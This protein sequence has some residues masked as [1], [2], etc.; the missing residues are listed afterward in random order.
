MYTSVILST[1]LL[2]CKHHHHL[3]PQLLILQKWSKILPILLPPVPHPSALETLILLPMS[4]LL[5]TL[6]T[7]YKWNHVVF[8]FSW[9]GYFTWCK[10]SQGPSMLMQMAG[11][12][13][14]FTAEFWSVVYMPHFPYPFI[15]QW[16]L[17][18]F[19]C[20]GCCK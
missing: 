17:R 12:S 1:F 16:K 6:G 9:M 13:F 8:V 3:F 10:C 14:F 19:P 20:L 5:T 2:L 7:S 15:H 18:L 11:T 4:I